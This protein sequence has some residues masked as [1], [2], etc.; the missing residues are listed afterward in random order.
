MRR[1]LP[2]LVPPMTARQRDYHGR[3]YIWRCPGCG[4]EDSSYDLPKGWEEVHIGP[5]ASR[6]M[7][8][9]GDCIAARRWEQES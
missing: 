8:R 2:L 1:R 9:C 4:A 5:H 3:E 7:F 6:Y